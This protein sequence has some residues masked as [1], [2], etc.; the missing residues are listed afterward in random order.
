MIEIG[1]SVSCRTHWPKAKSGGRV[2]SN[3]PH[4]HAAFSR[5]NKLWAQSDQHYGCFRR[6]GLSIAPTASPQKIS[7]DISRVR[8]LDRDS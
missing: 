3:E 1:L 7:S 4:S 6:S 5:V 2:D 8:V